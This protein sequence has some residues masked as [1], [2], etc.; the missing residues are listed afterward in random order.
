MQR[1]YLHHHHRCFPNFGPLVSSP[2][3]SRHFAPEA[4]QGSPLSSFGY[5][6]PREAQVAVRQFLC[7][8]S[9]WVGRAQVRPS[10]RL[11]P[12][13][14]ASSVRC[15]APPFEFRSFQY[16]LLNSM[17]STVWPHHPPPCASVAHVGSS[18]LLRAALLTRVRPSSARA[19]PRPALADRAWVPRCCPWGARELLPWHPGWA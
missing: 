14:L 13:C 16:R 19:G 1:K 10:T 15:A 3:V 17:S 18:L 2:P 5:V 7:Q 4:W 11:A 8:P 12:F 6:G 9:V